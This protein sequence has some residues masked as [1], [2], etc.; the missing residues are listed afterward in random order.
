MCAHLTSKAAAIT[1]APKTESMAGFIRLSITHTHPYSET[2]NTILSLSL[3]QTRLQVPT[4]LEKK[5]ASHTMSYRVDGSLVQFVESMNS[6]MQQDWGASSA[7]SLVSRFHVV[8]K[9]RQSE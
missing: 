2:K 3:S 6:C 1:L 7:W 8:L 9:C 5:M 4:M